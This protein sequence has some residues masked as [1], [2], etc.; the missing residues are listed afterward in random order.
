MQS[1]KNPDLKGKTKLEIVKLL[2]QN[3]KMELKEV[4]K[5]RNQ[6]LALELPQMERPQSNGLF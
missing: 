2:L 6:E 4:S 1:I 3:R 5:L